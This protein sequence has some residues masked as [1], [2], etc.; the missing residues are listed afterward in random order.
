M[1][2]LIDVEF[3]AKRLYLRLTVLW[4]VNQV[5]N[6]FLILI[7]L[8]LSVFQILSG[9]MDSGTRIIQVE[10]NFVAQSVAYSIQNAQA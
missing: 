7:K 5:T 1:I 9:S 2:F 4:S 8:K 6:E 3:R 10:M